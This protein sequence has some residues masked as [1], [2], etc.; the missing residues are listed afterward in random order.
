[1]LETVSI[2]D[3]LLEGLPTA[4]RLVELCG[5]P[6]S[7]KTALTYTQIIYFSSCFRLQYIVDTLVKDDQAKVI[8]LDN[9]GYFPDARLHSL[10]STK[11]KSD[12]QKY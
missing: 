6:F 4:G 3:R 10:L 2:L 11:C 8:Y 12:E 5:S 7:G 1:M 9:H